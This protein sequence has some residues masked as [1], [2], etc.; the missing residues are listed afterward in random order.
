MAERGQVMRILPR[1]PRGTWLLAGLVWLAGC[2]ILWRVLPVRPRAEWP[3]TGVKQL[4][5]FAPA[6]QAFVT[7]SYRG[8]DAEHPRGISC[9]PLRSWEADSGRV[10]EWF[11][12][13]EEINWPT[14]SP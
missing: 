7:Y 8:P 9:G 13:G 5:G 6:R 14:L 11:D 2:A 3:D 1:T 4:V 12:A 10:V